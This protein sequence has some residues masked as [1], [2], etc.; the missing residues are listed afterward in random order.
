MIIPSGFS[1]VNL[2]FTGPD[3]PTGAEMT[4]GVDNQISSFAP[5]DVADLEI[6]TQT[7]RF[8]EY[9]RAR[10]LVADLVVVVVDVHLAIAH[11]R[12]A[13]AQVLEQVVVQGDAQLAAAEI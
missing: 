10:G 1:Q 6:V 7:L 13:L 3:V 4:F 11:A 9:M 8:Q 12:H 5:G 2:K